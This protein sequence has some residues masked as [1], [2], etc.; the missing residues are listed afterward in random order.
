MFYNQPIA[1]RFGNALA[2]DI[3]SGKWQ[4]LEMA[5]A[6]V[7]HSG[8]RH[9]A[10]SF[11][12][13]LRRGAVAQVTVGVDIENTSQEGLQDL[14]T[15]QNHGPIDTY[16]YHN[17]AGDNV[18]HPKVYLLSSPDEAR[19]IVGSNNLTGAGLLANTEAGL[20]LD[21]PVGDPIISDARAALAQWRDLTTGFVKKLDATLL[22]DLVRLSYVFPER[23]LRER[24][25]IITNQ[26]KSR[27]R[28]RNQALFR[29]QR[30]S[31]PPARITPG[32]RLHVPGTI[33][34]MRVRKA[35][36]T[37]IQIPIRV[38]RTRFFAGVNEL[39]SAHNVRHPL[40]HAEA[41]TPLNWNYQRAIQWLIRFFVWNGLRRQLF[42]KPSMPRIHAAARFAKPC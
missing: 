1:H 18:F 7:R 19:L 33:L 3:E 28:T 17:E 30:V 13:F 34:L 37:Q 9:L 29:S 32:Q 21:A 23:Q 5:V 31:R 42:M 24:R 26:A 20:Q 41:L 38:V 25:R 14:L 12:A 27:R 35:R 11:E 15:W 36:R 2:A 16:V 40:V 39:V 22:N 10:P 4:R 8:T 6:W